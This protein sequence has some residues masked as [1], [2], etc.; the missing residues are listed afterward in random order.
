MLDVGTIVM[1]ETNMVPDPVG[2]TFFKTFYFVL[3]Y[4]Q[5]TM[6]W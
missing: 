5:L 2:F 4:N 3:G 6:V 1:N